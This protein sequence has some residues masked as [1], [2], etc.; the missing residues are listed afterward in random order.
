MSHTHTV[1]HSMGGNLVV[2]GVDCVCVHVAGWL[3][4]MVKNGCCW[5]HM[6]GGGGIVCVCVCVAE[7]CGVGCCVWVWSLVG[8]GEVHVP[9]IS[10]AH[11]TQH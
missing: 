8:L 4:Y 11:A 1:S 9:Q 6:W 3:G 7:Y 10:H 2:V 5:M